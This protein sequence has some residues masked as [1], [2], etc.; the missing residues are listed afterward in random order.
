MMFHPSRFPFKFPLNYVAS[1]IVP[2]A[3]PLLLSYMAI[4]TTFHRR[5]S[6]DRIAQE[7]KVWA[8][9]YGATS[10]SRS[11]AATPASGVEDEQRED[12]GTL[13]D[14]IMV[15]NEFD[16][17]QLERNRIAQMLFGVGLALEEGE[18]DESTAA[19]PAPTPTSSHH[20]SHDPA[21]GFSTRQVSWANNP[22]E[23]TETRAERLAAV[24]TAETPLT[25]AQQRMVRSLNA[26]SGLKKR[27]A[28][29]GDRATVFNAHSV[30]IVRR[31]HIKANQLGTDVVHHLASAFLV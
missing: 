30:I 28:Y 21:T 25:E 18:W 26:V 6:V 4:Q 1:L 22:E 9:I 24:R 17:E 14:P 20:V 23:S 16:E 29:F 11:G 2:V 13:L 19:T 31:P 7:R 5:A 3:L 10:R 8:K 15:L 12:E 27:I